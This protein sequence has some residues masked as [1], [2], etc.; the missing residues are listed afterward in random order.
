MFAECRNLT[1]NF[2]IFVIVIEHRLIIASKT[3][4][5]YYKEM[6]KEC[7]HEEDDREGFHKKEKLSVFY[8]CPAP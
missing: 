8:V 6:I 5:L 2:N 7:R 4:F 3:L 1:Y